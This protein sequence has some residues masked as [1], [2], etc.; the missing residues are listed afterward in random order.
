MPKLFQINS[1]LNKGS[2]GRIAEQIASLAQSRGWETYI[3]HGARYQCVSI[4][5]NFQVVTKLGELFHAL[6]SFLYDAHGLGSEKATWKLIDEIERIEP[7]II[8][9]HNLHGYYINY[10]VLFKY[11][12]NRN[13]P[14]VWTLHDCWAMTG[15]CCHFDLAGCVKWKTGCYD[16]V[17]RAG[18]PKS[19]YRDKSKYN[20]QLKKELF[21][22][23]SNMIIVPVSKWMGSIVGHSYL[24]RYPINVINNGVDISVFRPRENDLRAR[25]GLKDKIVLLGVATAWSAS[26]GLNDYVKLSS[27]LSNDYQIIL[28][29]VNQ[30]LR[31]K[32]PSNII[33]IA[34]TESQEELAEYYSM[35]DVVL[36]LSYQESFG[37]TTV[38]GL[39]CGTPG[40]VYNKT[41]SPELINKETGVIVEVGNMEQVISAINYIIKKGK[42]FY[43]SACVER[44]RT[45]FDKDKCFHRYIELYE[46]LLKRKKEKG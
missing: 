26:K 10:K 43:S 34:R 4:M 1:S 28:V 11:L 9:I 40:I 12:Q 32:I 14:I 41:A 24:N 38:E 13:V 37:L 33:C 15:H 22:S 42:E 44:A 2:T 18:Y 7:D 6:K 29:G 16:C 19:L 8:H 39:A 21:T 46:E 36:N 20:Y 17:L 30:K 45:S 5:K 3:A 25:F 23:V 35:A 31:K 27:I